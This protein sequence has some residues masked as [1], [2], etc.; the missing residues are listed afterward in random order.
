MTRRNFPRSCATRSTKCSSAARFRAGAKIFCLTPEYRIQRSDSRGDVFRRRVSSL[1]T[2]TK[3]VIWGISGVH[4]GRRVRARANQLAG[5]KIPLRPAEV[6]IRATVIGASQ[7]TV[8]VSGNTIY[9]SHPELLPLRNLQV[10]TPNLSREK[11]SRPPKS[12]AAFE[13]LYSV[14]TFSIRPSRSLA[15]RWELVLPIL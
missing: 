3:S 2:A 8:Q 7:Y 5:G 12:P 14:S 15:I 10:V 9:L 1:S 13:R 4:L 6:R 11:R